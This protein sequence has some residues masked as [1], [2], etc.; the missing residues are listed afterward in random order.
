VTT[1][2]KFLTI[3]GIST[4]YLE[5]GD[6]RAPHLVL[7]HGGEFGACAELAYEATIEPLSGDFHVLAPDLIGYG[8]TDKIVEFGLAHA[9]RHSRRLK[10]LKSLVGALGIPA[11]DFVGNSVGGVMLTMDAASDQPLLP[12]RRLVSITGSGATAPAARE[13]L[14]GFDGTAASMRAVLGMLFHDVERWC[15]DS[16]VQRR[17]ASALMPG[18]FEAASSAR[19]RSLS[20]K[21]QPA[22]TANDPTPYEKISVPVMIAIG[23]HEKC[24]PGWG[25]EAA[26]RIPRCDLKVFQHSA[27]CCQL[28]EP[29]AFNGALREFLRRP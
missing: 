11:A 12:I 22:V 25:P 24:C 23:A 20:A 1:A 6:P 5:A 13:A 19:I 27:H 28:E 16:Y 4:H 3:D 14:L 8:T 21:S 26:R 2:S 18:A 9:N 15:S 7:V 17:L 10:H 29:D